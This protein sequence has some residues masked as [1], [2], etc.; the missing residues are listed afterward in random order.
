MWTASAGSIRL[1]FA[2]PRRGI[3]DD[4][5]N[6]FSLYAEQLRWSNNTIMNSYKV[7]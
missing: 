2:D 3:Q 6:G 1:S 5:V 4:V 7:P